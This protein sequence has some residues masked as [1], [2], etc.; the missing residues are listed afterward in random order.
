MQWGC[1]LKAHPEAPRPEGKWKGPNHLKF[2][3]RSTPAFMGFLFWTFYGKVLSECSQT[4]T[5][6]VEANP[7]PSH[8]LK[9]YLLVRFGLLYRSG[10]LH[11]RVRVWLCP[12]RCACMYKHIHI[13]NVH[14]N[15]YTIYIYIYIYVYTYVCI[16]VYMGAYICIYIYTCIHNIL[17][18][19][20]MYI[21]TYV[22][23]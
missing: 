8:C 11:R 22:S 2:A 10:G 5:T 13:Y 19:Q 7:L 12:G 6:L 9:K 18:I 17:Y 21:Y 1:S 20:Y 16:Y 4:L 23:I 3:T 15:I 14:M